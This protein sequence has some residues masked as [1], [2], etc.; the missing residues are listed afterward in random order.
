MKKVLFLISAV[1]WVF[2]CPAFVKAL[3]MEIVPSSQ[4]TNQWDFTYFDLKIHNDLDTKTSFLV[5]V[6]GP[7]LFWKIPGDFLLVLDAGETRTS[8]MVFRPTLEGRFDYKVRVS[9]FS[10]PKIFA[11]SSFFMDVVGGVGLSNLQARV[12]DQRLEISLD[13]F[14][15]EKERVVLNMEILDSEGMVV[16][17]SEIPVYVEDVKQVSEKMSLSGIIAGNYTLRA[18]TGSEMVETQFNIAPLRDVSKEYDISTGLLRDEIIITITNKG[19]VVEDLVFSEDVGTDALT[20]FVTKPRSCVAT[21]ESKDCEFVVEGL[22]PGEKRRVTYTIEYWPNYGKYVAGFI[23]LALIGMYS[24]GE[25]SKPRIVKKVVK[26]QPDGHTVIIEVKN[27]FKELDSVIVRD[28]VSP[29]ARVHKKFE[30]LSPVS[31]TSDAGTELVW[32]IGK[33]RPREVR[34]LSYRVKPLVGG[35]LKMPKAYLRFRNKNG[36]R[37]K[38]YSKHLVV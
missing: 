19:N 34:I 8:R 31:K 20:G 7:Y 32:K 13:V 2:L 15:A 4:K 33:M 30:H 9:S 10:N 22:A 35:Q 5:D 37:V 24:V 14:S 27:P 23:I 26:R 36:E 1:L 17:A 21:P 25:A 11:E 18:F 29:L 3:A 6:N 28:F 38:V 12:S 16:T